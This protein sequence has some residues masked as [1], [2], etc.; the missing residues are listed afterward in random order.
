MKKI[1]I[2]IITLSLFLTP[3]SV[4]Q[5]KNKTESGDKTETVSE[6]SK[7]KETDKKSDEETEPTTQEPTTEDNSTPRLM[8]TDYKL[9]KKSLSPGEKAVLSVTFKNYSNT[10][11]VYNVKL[12]LSDQSG[13]IIATGMPTKYVRAIYAGSTYTWDIE[14]TAVNT[15]SV[16]QHDLE[17]AAEYEDKYYA[18][19]SASDTVRIDVK[20]SVKLKYSGA[21]LPKKVVQGSNETVS[22]ELMNTGKST[23][24]NCMV[25]F[26]IENMSSGGSVYV[27]N[28]EPA[29]SSSC[30][31]N[32]LVDT[33][34]L[35]ESKGKIIITY[36]DS[37][38]KE[39]TK[40]INVSTVI[41]EKVEI[42]LNES[43]DK[44]NEKSNS[45]WWVFIIIGIIFGAGVG[46]AVMKIMND[47]KQRKEDD[48]RL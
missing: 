31:A 36:E 2:Y 8:V 43:E 10:K 26:D 32:L 18:S 5:A 46:F 29:Q 34:A 23:V 45:L 1:I 25:D 33:K 20:Q 15:T 13:E 24:Y 4:A 9:S 16:G 48:L 6:V 19:F 3:V 21:T 40:K 12:S 27:G 47:K 11:A 42:V 7:K 14:L 30:S 17:I 38:G 22:M 41:E 37:Y 39:Y 44:E 35:G 28:I